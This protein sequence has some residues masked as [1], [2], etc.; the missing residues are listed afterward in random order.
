MTT[1]VGGGKERQNN[2]GLI[3]LSS[4]SLCLSKATHVR[5]AVLTRRHVTTIGVRVRVRVR[6]QVG[7]AV[8]VNLRLRFSVGLGLG[9]ILGLYRSLS[10]RH[11]HCHVC[12]LSH[13]F[14]QVII[15]AHR[16]HFSGVAIQG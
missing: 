11:T 12:S 7:F 3:R 1:C 10:D 16:Y 15:P 5:G 13:E 9:L 4:Y 6:I 8:G 2:K 14:I